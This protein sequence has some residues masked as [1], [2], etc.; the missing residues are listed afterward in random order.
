MADN[1]AD[2]P[3]EQMSPSLL[4]MQP[5]TPR[6]KL[7]KPQSDWETIFSHLTARMGMMRAWRWSWWAYWSRLAEFFLPRR[8]HWVVV[9]NRMQR[10]SPINDA[11]IDSTA[12][13][14]IQICASGLWT[15]LTSPS[16]P[17]FKFEKAMEWLEID[18]EGQEWMDDTTKKVETVLAQSN[19]YTSMAQARQDEVV[20]GTSPL[21]IYEDY[22]D[23]V[24]FYNPCAGEYYLA[25]GARLSVDTLYREFT[26][27]VAQIVEQ[28]T[29]EEC[30]EQVQKLW[31]AAGASLENEFVVAHA[32][33][34]NFDLANRTD[35]RGKIKV[36]PSIFTYREIYWLKGIKTARPLSKRGFR[37]KPFFVLTWSRVSN[38]PYGR[39]PGMDALGDQKQVQKETVRKAEFLE[40][41]VRPSMGADASLKNEPASIMPGMIT[42]MSTAGGEKKFFP[43]FEVNPGWMPHIMADIEKVSERIK[44]C[45]FEDVFMAIS[46]MEGVQPRNELELTKRDL[47]RLQSLGPMITAD[48]NELSTMILRVLAIMQ[49]RRVRGPDGTMQPL[50]KPMPASLKGVPLKI[51][52]TS[53][54]RLAQR[55]AE[56]VAMKDCFA[57]GGELSSAAKAAGVPD[58]LRTL[59]LDKAY[60]HYCEAS[61]F[62]AGLFYTD[63]EVKQHDA[64][65]AQ[66]MQK[67]QAP[68]QAMAAVN[69]AKT[70]SETSTGGGSA[71][72]AL[73]GPQ[74]GAPGAGGV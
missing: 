62:P 63:D 42:Y 35:P 55:A 34:P 19:F 70:L 66:A 74:G 67:A 4:A 20:F 58:P 57:T 31:N 50:L 40:K 73:M 47:E 3:Y 60:K 61:N 48:E 8:Y 65:R 44:R 24:R 5:P 45:F 52:Y 18:S 28:F 23:V 71:L 25:V 54:M 30:P 72:S 16:R 26:L 36:V 22:E 49:R 56:A 33:E 37:E 43:L 17:W 39:S 13:L 1:Y 14:S 9:A 53:I 10:G 29:L 2:A 59:N 27:T 41:G 32:I 51:G 69:A 64:I 46:R 21:I 11:I 38:D 7:E 68:D 6:N 15:G 12:T